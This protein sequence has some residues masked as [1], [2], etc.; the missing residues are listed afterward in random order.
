MSDDDLSDQ[1]SIDIPINTR[2]RS[3]KPPDR[4]KGRIASDIEFSSFNALDESDSYR[5]NEAEIEMSS[6]ISERSSWSVQSVKIPPR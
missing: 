6:G 4:R 3:S 1:A 2:S 5:G